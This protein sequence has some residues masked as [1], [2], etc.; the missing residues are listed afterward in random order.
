MAFLASFC[1]NEK[2]D[3]DRAYG[4]HENN[5]VCRSGLSLDCHRRCVTLFNTIFATLQLGFFL[6]F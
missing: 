6:H 3:S 2:R 1:E 4:I 5:Y